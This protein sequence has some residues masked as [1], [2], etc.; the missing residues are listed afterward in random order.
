MEPDTEAYTSDTGASVGLSIEAAM[1]LNDIQW[2]IERDPRGAQTAALRLVSLLRQLENCASSARR[3]GL[4]PWQVR[5]VDRYLRATM[6]RSLR[7]EDLAR[8]VSLSTNYFGRAFKASFG[9]TPHMYIMRLRVELAKR[10]MLTT[11]DQL[12]EI[13][14]LCG[15]ADQAH[16]SKLFRR[17]V[18]DTPGAWRRQNLRRDLVRRSPAAHP[19]R[20]EN[21]SRS[22]PVIA[23][24]ANQFPPGNA[25]PSEAGRGNLRSHVHQIATSLRSSR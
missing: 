20:D 10:L 4:A 2:M 7:V 17:E 13:A 14:L 21:G 1:V 19:T 12:S 15:L 22:P 9:T 18:G 25:S 5:K 8:Q 16:L 24:A 6:D 23:R 11:Q 3:G